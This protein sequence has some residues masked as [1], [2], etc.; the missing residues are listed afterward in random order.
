MV[1]SDRRFNNGQT[2]EQFWG[3]LQEHQEIPLRLSQ[4][5][6]ISKSDEFGNVKVI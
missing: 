5:N 1:F 2:L 6:K 3:A 4:R